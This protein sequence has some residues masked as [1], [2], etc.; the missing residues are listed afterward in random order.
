[1][2]SPRGSPLRSLCLPALARGRSITRTETTGMLHYLGDAVLARA[3]TATTRAAR[4]ERGWHRRLRARTHGREGPAVGDAGLQVP[5]LAFQV[6]LQPAAVLALERTQVVD[7]ALKFLAGLDQRTHGLAVP[8]LRV[9]LQALGPGACVAGDLLRL[10]PGLG[11]HL[12]RL[13]AGAAQGLVGL[14][15]GVGNGLVGGLL[16]Q[17]E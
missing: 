3:L 17:R 13:A 8:L 1:M 2:R 5:E 6:S 4:R 11:E 10:A 16:R 15:A 7:P 9:A 14:P 12:V